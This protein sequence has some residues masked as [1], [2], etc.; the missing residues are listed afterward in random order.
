MQTLATM[1]I[2]AFIIRHLSIYRAQLLLCLTPVSMWADTFRTTCSEC[3]K[4]LGPTAA[5][6][7]HPL[8]TYTLVSSI[9]G[10]LNSQT[11][12]DQLSMYVVYVKA[13]HP[14]HFRLQIVVKISDIP[15]SQEI[16]IFYPLCITLLLF[17]A[18]NLMSNAERLCEH[19]LLDICIDSVSGRFFLHRE[20]YA[21][22]FW[23]QQQQ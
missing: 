9:Q 22:D 6:L 18:I 1:I 10:A 12:T 11:L 19:I 15:V 23:Q 3:Y 17:L 8:F 7:Y 20:Q 16:Q 4:T 5:T 14:E 13:C 21:L 2:T